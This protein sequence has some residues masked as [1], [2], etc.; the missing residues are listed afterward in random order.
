MAQM[1]V[2][3]KFLTRVWVTTAP[4]KSIIAASWF[5]YVVVEGSHVR[6]SEVKCSRGMVWS[7]N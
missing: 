2:G 4:V 5:A 1:T 6:V 7:L 3:N